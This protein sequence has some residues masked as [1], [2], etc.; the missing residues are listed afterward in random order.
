MMAIEEECRDIPYLKTSVPIDKAKGMIWGVFIGDSLGA[1]CE[2]L[3]GNH[4]RVENY[5]GLFHDDWYVE[6]ENRGHMTRFSKGM[7]TDDSEMTT[8]MLELVI[9]QDVTT[10][11][12]VRSFMSWANS[13][14]K[15][16]G[17]NTRAL[18]YGYK[19][20]K[21]YSCRFEET[22]PTTEK[23]EQAQSNGHLMRCSPIALIDDECER[24]Q[25]I[26][27]NTQ[28]SNP[29][30]ICFE[31]ENLYVEVLRQC[32]TSKNEVNEERRLI[33]SRLEALCTSMPHGTIKDA[34][35]DALSNKF[36]RSMVV[37]KAWTLNAFSIALFHLIHD[38]SDFQSAIDSVIE[39]GGD[40]DTNMAIAGAL[41]GALWG[42][43]KMM[44]NENTAQNAMVIASCVPVQTTRIGKNGVLE[45]LE[46]PAK[47]QHRYAMQL[48]AKLQPADSTVA[49]SPQS[50]SSRDESNSKEQ[51]PIK[52]CRTTT[53]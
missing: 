21:T 8:I 34:L 33:R 19:K 2:K 51:P 24:E 14:T 49:Y 16:L 50:G 23:R 10:R 5:T 29:S 13:N 15:S 45:K 44:L 53:I 3:K 4:Q 35:T 7:P 48:L 46:R 32:L 11:T 12:L 38:F 39:F 6:I 43:K 9:R 28:V 1:P 36:T 17:R 40:T 37:N 41:L 47:Y 30:D 42:E 18:F 31:V 26:F 22:F 52:K 20:E 27:T 25:A